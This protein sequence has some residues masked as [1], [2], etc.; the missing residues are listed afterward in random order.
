MG[1]AA[2]LPLSDAQRSA[3]AGEVANLGNAQVP[4]GIGGALA[5]S[6]RAIIRRDVVDT[7]RVVVY[8]CIAFA[9]ISALCAATL[10]SGR[11]Q[12]VRTS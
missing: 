7:F 1:S 10:L 11:K 12:R 6:L 3:L 4:Y 8:V 2:S 9:W 5:E